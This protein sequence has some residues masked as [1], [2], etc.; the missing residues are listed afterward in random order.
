MNKPWYLSKGIWAGILLILKGIFYDLLY[1][2]DA[3]SASQTFL[4]GLGCLGIRR[5]IPEE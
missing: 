5:A 4:L 1:A 3:A 2:G